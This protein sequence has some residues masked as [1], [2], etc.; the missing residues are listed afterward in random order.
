MKSTKVQTLSELRMHSTANLWAGLLV[1]RI[2]LWSPTSSLRRVW[3]GL[4]TVVGSTRESIQSF[5][6]TSCSFKIHRVR[7]P[8]RGKP[9][10]I[11]ITLVFHTITPERNSFREN[12]II[13]DL[14]S[15]PWLV[16]WET[17]GQKDTHD[18]YHNPHCAWMPRWDILLQ[19]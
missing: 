5:V 7:G 18:N 10:L 17:E 13:F 2:Y 9:V 3:Q 14:W 16:K 11:S 12:P 4:G 15:N 6:V 8:G 19:M 1:V